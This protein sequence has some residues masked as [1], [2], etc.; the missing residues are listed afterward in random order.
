MFSE[1]GQQSKDEWNQAVLEGGLPENS[2]GP[3]AT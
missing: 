3:F 2:Q 1:Q